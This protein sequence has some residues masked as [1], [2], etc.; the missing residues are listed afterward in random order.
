MENERLLLFKRKYVIIIINRQPFYTVY[1]DQCF[2]RNNVKLSFKRNDQ[3]DFNEFKIF[4]S[5]FGE[6]CVFNYLFIKQ[7]VIT[8]LLK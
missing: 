1:V 5:C 7:D 2:V 4:K 3:I 8:V 6:F